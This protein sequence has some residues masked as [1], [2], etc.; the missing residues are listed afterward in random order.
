MPIELR[1][2]DSV[3]N[4]IQKLT[5]TGLNKEADLKKQ[6]LAIFGELKAS[7]YWRHTAY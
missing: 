7:V 2:T 3:S 1:N 4:Q 5:F 6:L